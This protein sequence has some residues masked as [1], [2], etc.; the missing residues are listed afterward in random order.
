MK[1]VIVGGVAGGAT[2]AARLRRLDESVEIVMI[3]RSGF[4]SY[5]NCGLPYFIGGV[6]EDANE[7][8]LQTPES[9][10][11]RFNIDVRVKQEVLSIDR[12][13]KTVRVRKLDDGTEYIESY[14]KLLL[15]PGA[16]PVRPPVPGA[17]DE[18]IMTLRTVEDTMRIRAFIDEKQPKRAVVVGGGSIGLEVAENL[19]EAGIETTL[20]ELSPQVFPP[21][22]FDMACMVHAHLRDHGL[23]LRLETGANGYE[24]LEA[25]DGM[26]VVLSDGSAIDAD[27]VIMGVGVAPETTLA[28]DAGLELGIRKAIVVD[29]H[30]RTSD[31]DIY[32][33][34]D[35]VQVKQSVTG[36]DAFIAL[37]GPA[38]KEA[39]IA[40]TNIAGGDME[41]LGSQGSSILKLFD[42]TIAS[43]GL[44]EKGAQAAGIDYKVVV[45]RPDSHAEFYPGG[46]MMT[47]K[48]LYAPADGRILGA[49]IVGFE[50][51][52]KHIDVFATAIRAEMTADDLAQLDLAYAPPFSSAKD[53]A[54]L[55]GYVIQNLRAGLFKSYSIDESE[56]LPRDGSVT[57]LD[58]R[59]PEEFANGSL[60]GAI[61]VCVDGI[62]EHLDQIPKDKPVYV[63][64]GMGMRGYVACRVL[65][66]HGYDCKNLMGGFAFYR[67][68]KR[69]G[70]L[71]KKSATACG[72]EL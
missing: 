31:P 56:E 18:R 10:D 62:R 34:G 42:L 4:I 40:A 69:G 61:N 46:T 41:Y 58:I 60:E 30:M 55:V 5:A 35:A 38:N 50:S 16:K 24:R 33:V 37:A 20:V 3:E 39:R 19:V 44:N 36:Q 63:I 22:D 45:L 43:T 7:L 9:F 67:E 54:N 72:A 8:T 25:G 11:A 28:A 27:L 66:Q 59:T 65:E 26:R 21:F 17:D 53:P 23:D 6:I 52:D 15:S 12:S 32:A 51:I 14:D 48:V 47:M 64:C 49:Q 68:V 70:G 29:S 1:V 71:R 13:A 57:L 2:A